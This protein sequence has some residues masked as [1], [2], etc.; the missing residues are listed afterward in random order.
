MMDNSVKLRQRDRDAKKRRKGNS[1]L[2][3]PGKLC[4]L[5]LT[6]RKRP[7]KPGVCGGQERGT[8]MTWD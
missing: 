8:H 5:P 2:P 7:K 6:V 3:S 4:S 1:F